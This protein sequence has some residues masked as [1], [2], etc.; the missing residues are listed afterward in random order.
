MYA[1]SGKLSA[2]S[3][4]VTFCSIRSELTPPVSFETS[5][6]GWVLLKSSPIASNSLAGPC[7]CPCQNSISTGS[8][9]LAD[10]SELPS[11]SPSPH[12]PSAA[13]TAAAASP[14]ITLVSFNTI[15]SSRA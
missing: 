11:S 6:S 10:E 14:M 5:M 12:A 4:A 15:L 1:M 3:P 7:V 2:C 9:L 8:P 13:M